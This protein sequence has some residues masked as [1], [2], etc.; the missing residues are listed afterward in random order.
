M[1]HRRINRGID[2]RK[3]RY[4]PTLREMASGVALRSR[5]IVSDLVQHLV[6]QGGL[7]KEKETSRTLALL[8]AGY[9]QIDKPAAVSA[10]VKAEDSLAAMAADPAIQQE[11]AAI[12]AEF[13]STEE[14]GLP[15]CEASAQPAA[16]PG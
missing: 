13:A 4:R 9:R 1:H 12:Q 3:R 10:P 6:E 11:L 8:E 15:A 16:R 2:K 5:S 14:D 7:R